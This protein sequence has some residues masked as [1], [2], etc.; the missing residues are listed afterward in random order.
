[1]LRSA[2]AHRKIL[3]ELAPP[4]NQVHHRAQ[5]RAGTFGA[6]CWIRS[7][8]QLAGR[9]F[10]TKM[11]RYWKDYIERWLKRNRY[12]MRSE[13]NGWMDELLQ[14][15][16]LKGGI[17]D[18]SDE[19][20]VVIARWFLRSCGLRGSSFEDKQRCLLAESEAVAVSSCIYLSMSCNHPELEV[21]AV[22][23]LAVNDSRQCFLWSIQDARKWRVF[24]QRD[25]RSC[26]T[27]GASRCNGRRLGLRCSSFLASD[28]LRPA[29]AE[30][31]PQNGR[32][33][34][35]GRRTSKACCGQ[36]MARHFYAPGLRWFPG[37]DLAL[38][39]FFPK[40]LG[41]RC[42]FIDHL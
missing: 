41:F 12:M 32:C 5:W 23:F 40:R 2:M 35:G 36:I 6:C 3:V 19:V 18:G 4:A 26:W 33:K 25:K 38:C 14:A 15:L 29:P 27:S 13:K 20:C 11:K 16:H 31:R 39:F 10:F 30:E 1:M 28:R 17:E 9:C 34:N 42:R 21:V 24:K 7:R 37:L 8:S 22:M